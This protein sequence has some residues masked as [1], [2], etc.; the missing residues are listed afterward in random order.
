MMSFVLQVCNIGAEKLNYADGITL[1]NLHISFICIVTMYG[2][3]LYPIQ[4]QAK[5]FLNKK[6][7]TSQEGGSG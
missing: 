7:K 6:E 4:Y 1:N 3:I 2:L 5:S